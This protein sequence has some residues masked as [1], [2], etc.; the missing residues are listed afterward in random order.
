M[1]RATEAAEK[2]SR[3]WRVLVPETLARV[4]ALWRTPELPGLEAQ[5]SA[6]LADWLE[7][8]GFSITRKAHGLPTAFVARKGHGNGPRIAIL[9]EYDA[10]PGLGNEVVSD[11]RP[12]GQRAGHGCG[13]N[14]IGPVN[15]AAAIAAASLGLAGEVAIIGCPAEEILW[16]KVALL[17]A[18]AFAGFDAIL[19]SHGDYQNGALS[20]PCQAV[21]STEFV[22]AGEAG[23]GGLQGPCNAL[24]GA[25]AALGRIGAIAF[26]G[27]CKHVLRRAGTMPSITPEEARLWIV[28]RH[29]DFAAVRRFHGDMVSAA[30]AAAAETGTSV[31]EQFIAECRGYLANDVLAGVLQGELE[32]VGPPAWSEAEIGFMRELG[33]ACAPGQGF[34][35]DR[36]LAL[37]G[38]GED[39]YGQDDGEAS[40]RVP[41]GRVNWAYPRQVPIHH[42]AWTALSGHSA[43]HRGALMASE[44]LARA[45][46]RLLAEPDHVVRARAEL[47]RRLAGRE[48][49]S[50]RLG[51]WATMTAA[52]E[53]F[54]D[55]SWRETTP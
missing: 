46:A 28:A 42:W 32:A 24:A 40:W 25:E 8:H 48:V 21:V 39:Y 9:A 47:D 3:A 34:D 17:R 33:A 13:H 52:P 54:W 44:A 37:Y 20:R 26:A 19:T 27:S 53:R 2:A 16:G 11:R 22:F 45:A 4:E 49:D 31:A 7:G 1:A 38:E 55:A 29:V 18:G 14:H 10:L 50:P 23:H 5:S 15:C 36:G 30:Q 43:G 6:L 41:L 35:L 12:T 51:A